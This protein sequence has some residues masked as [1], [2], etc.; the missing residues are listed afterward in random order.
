MAKDLSGEYVRAI[1]EHGNFSNAARAL[2]ISQPYLSKFIK[3]LEDD[4]GVELINRNETPITLTYA[5][6]RYLTYIDE[7]EKTYLSMKYEIE[8]ITNMKKGRLK[9]GINP[10]LGSH[11]LYNLLP[12]YMST[13]PG[14]E[15][16]L[17]EA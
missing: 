3:K 1:A 6:E 5:G 11:T 8:A 13:Y 12:Q 4:L 17:I 7:I 9:I 14:I 2:F 10:I 16:D 15:I